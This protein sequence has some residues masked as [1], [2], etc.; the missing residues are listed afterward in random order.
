MRSGVSTF[1]AALLVALQSVAASAES[2]PLDAAAIRAKVAAA[3]GARPATYRQ[4]TVWT[5]PGWTETTTVIRRG[6]DF[7]EIVDEGSFHHED[8]SV[9]GHRWH[10]NENGQTIID[11]AV[12]D[13]LSK[14]VP[15]T[16][17]T[18]RRITTPV[19]GYAIAELDDQGH[20]TRELVDATTWRLVRRDE[21][22]AH[23]TL[24]TLFDDFRSERGYTFAHHTSIQGPK[25][26]VDGT[27]TAFDASPVA[28]DAVAIPPMRRLLVEFPAGKGSVDLPATFIDGEI[29]VRITVGGRGLDFV[30][31]T[32]ARG[33]TIDNGVARELGLQ[34]YG[35]YRDFAAGPYTSG[36]ARIPEMRVGDLTM[37]DVAVQL[38]PE[39]GDDGAFVKTVGLLGF[40]FLAEL[41]VTID[42][43]HQRVTVVREPDYR[44]PAGPHVIAL[45]ARVGEGAPYVPVA[46][47]GTPSNEFLLD[48][49]GQSTFLIFPA[50]A[51]R[52]PEALVDIGNGPT[53]PRLVFFTG[54]GGAVR[55]KLYEL[56]SV[57]VGPIDFRNQIGFVVTSHAYDDGDDGIIGS[58]FLRLFTVGLDY[59]NERV[60]LVPNAV[61]RRAMHITD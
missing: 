27:V 28:A 32:G 15:A 5:R 12:P 8:G 36:H 58:A 46:V 38:A 25:I 45:D 2:P 30:L 21:I 59:A 47:N 1:A 43:E 29:V 39:T 50:F 49:G 33:I 3:Q 14:T 55:T 57:R 35:E 4:T 24:T 13:E 44:P 56:K 11:H 52:H 6:E 23:F 7:R 41:G 34:T 16:T 9:D 19:D 17:T 20:G 18:V 10:Q 37:H 31:D 54:I 53:D 48:T 26:R 51:R 61:G 22:T 60:Y 40:D 42:Y